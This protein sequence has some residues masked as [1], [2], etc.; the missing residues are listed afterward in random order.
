M[1]PPRI[2]V[3]PGSEAL[4][5]SGAHILDPPL[6]PVGV[7]IPP[8]DL[9]DVT[10]KP[11]ELDPFCVN[12]PGS[13]GKSPAEFEK[14]EVVLV[15]HETPVLQPFHKLA[16]PI[17]PKTHATIPASFFRDVNFKVSFYLSIVLKYSFIKTFISEN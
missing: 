9:E 2:E 11:R 13:M 8:Q 7:Q 16:K 5:G 4:P 12:S 10:L 14:G 3:D 1:G 6:D 15:V 17:W